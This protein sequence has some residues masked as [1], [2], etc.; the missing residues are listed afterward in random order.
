[1]ITGVGGGWVGG[2]LGCFDRRSRRVSA[3][4]RRPRARR[5]PGR[6]HRSSIAI[7]NGAARVGASFV[8]ARRT[9]G[10]DPTTRATCVRSLRDL[11]TTRRDSLTRAVSSSPLVYSTLSHRE[12]ADESSTARAPRPLAAS[13]PSRA[14]VTR[15]RGRAREDEREPRDGRRRRRRRRR[16]GLVPR[17]RRRR[18]APAPSRASPLRV[19]GR[20]RRLLRRRR[21]LAADHR[22][23]VRVVT[24]ERDERHRGGDPPFDDVVVRSLPDWIKHRE[25]VVVMRVHV[26]VNLPRERHGDSPRDVHPVR[27]GPVREV[28]DALPAAA[29]DAPP[30]AVPR[31]YLR[32]VPYEAKSG[33]SSGVRQKRS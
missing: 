1:M 6:V 18:P 7:S 10:T 27:R 9:D 29:D 32:A 30:A 15:A 22:R 19:R 33:W 13:S 25:A 26:A 14:V 28:P 11:S 21:P 16:G 4:T 2:C 17:A 23:N 5:R 20:G 31:V 3:K 8:T 12:R 24:Q